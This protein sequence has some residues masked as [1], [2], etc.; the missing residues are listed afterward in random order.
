MDN[1]ILDILHL[2]EYAMGIGK[3]LDYKENCDVF[4]TLIMKRKNLSA[5][6]ILEKDEDCLHS[7]FSIP[8]ARQISKVP[9][10]EVAKYLPSAGTH[11]SESASKFPKTLFPLEISEGYVTIY[12][13]MDSGYLFLY[14][15]M[16]VLSKTAI[17][18][19]QPV[20][21]KFSRSLKACK[22]FSEQQTL[23]KNLEASNQDLADFAHVVS[24][25]LKSPLRGM[26]ALINWLKEDYASVLDDSAT[27]TFDL[28]L[29][30]VEKMDN[31]IEGILKYSSVDRR[32]VGTEE[33]NLHML[34]SDIIDLLTI[35]VHIHVHIPVQLPTIIG[36]R[37]R[38][39]QLF[40]NLLS[41]AIKS[42]DKPNGLIEVLFEEQ[43]GHWQFAIADNGVGISQAHQTKVFEIFETLEANDSNTGIGLS[44]VKKIVHFYKGK[45]WIESEVG[46]GTTFYF[47]LAKL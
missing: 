43:N 39:Q 21:D 9:F 10:A 18:Q 3:T 13:L 26:D 7:S 34:L 6:W 44:I 24:H 8:T 41:N 46:S 4:L 28:L 35:P 16:N 33:V 17:W 29:E 1:H 31:L 5:A 37:P 32:K 19:L 45:I 14:S 25:D 36:D 27:K 15:K 47:T 30:K 42:I 22:A 11:K 20:M 2:Y 12:H 23:L 40:Q 38:L